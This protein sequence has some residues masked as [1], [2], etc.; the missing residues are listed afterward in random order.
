MTIEGSDD[1]EK[2]FSRAKAAA[3]MRD[4]RGRRLD[5]ALAPVDQLPRNPSGNERCR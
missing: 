3:S 2:G 4:P 5:L 1:P